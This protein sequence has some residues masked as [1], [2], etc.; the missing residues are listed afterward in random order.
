MDG[1]FNV[2]IQDTYLGK[3]DHGIP[4]CRICVEGDGF[5][6]SFGNYELRTYGIDMI[7]SM[8]EIVGAKSWEDLKGR[9]ARVKIANAK[10][11]AI[12]HI[13]KDSWYNPEESEGNEI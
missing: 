4:T 10:V 8:I 12:G 5:G 2:T 9:Y 11:E 1:I 6:S 7:L 3:E 13:I